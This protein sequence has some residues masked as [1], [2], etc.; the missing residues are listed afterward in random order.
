MAPVIARMTSTFRALV[1]AYPEMKHDAVM[2]H[3]MQH[4]RSIIRVL[5]EKCCHAITIPANGF[6]LKESKASNTSTKAPALLVREAGI[7]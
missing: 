5:S 2:S 3:L 4:M 7:T 1:A 6:L